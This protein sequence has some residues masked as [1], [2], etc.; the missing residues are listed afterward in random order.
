M[1][2]QNGHAKSQTGGKTTTI[3]V[4][5]DQ[6]IGDSATIPDSYLGG[7]TMTHYA[8]VSEW[9]DGYS[10]VN[11]D[12]I[13]NFVP[14]NYTIY[15]HYKPIKFKVVYDKDG[16]ADVEGSMAS[17][18]ITYAELNHLTEVVESSASTT[19]KKIGHSFVN[20]TYTNKNL[21]IIMLCLRQKLLTLM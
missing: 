6:R 7:Y 13:Y 11:D 15:A 14:D 21:S 5:Y 19:F 10:V 20:W 2:G 18:E 3:K 8:T 12:T 4:R 16:D 1:D 9:R 17:Q